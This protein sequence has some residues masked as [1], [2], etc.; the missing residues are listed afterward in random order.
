MTQIGMVPPVLALR[1]L[2]SAPKINLTTLSERD[3]LSGTHHPASGIR[4]PRIFAFLQI[5]QTYHSHLI[6]HV[7]SSFPS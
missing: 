4:F 5:M 2:R 1:C 3:A 7:S 6:S